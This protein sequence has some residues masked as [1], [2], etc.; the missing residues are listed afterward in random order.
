MDAII[1]LLLVV[2]FYLYHGDSQ[3]FLLQ[4]LRMMDMIAMPEKQAVTIVKP[5]DCPEAK[6]LRSACRLDAPF[7]E[8]SPTNPKPYINP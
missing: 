2:V 1:V 7:P 8:Q 3:L 4:L 6:R 5:H